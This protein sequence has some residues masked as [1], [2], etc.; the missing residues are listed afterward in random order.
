MQIRCPRCLAI[1]QIS[2]HLVSTVT[3]CRSCGAMLAIPNQVR[4]AISPY[5]RLLG[6]PPAEQ[7]PS[8]RRLIGL[9]EYCNDPRQI[10]AAGQHQE[11]HLQAF[12]GGPHSTEAER[13][14][15]E[16]LH[17]Q[18][19]LLGAASRAMLA[20]Q[21]APTRVELPKTDYVP[22]PF[23]SAAPNFP[24][25]PPAAVPPTFNP[26]PG[27]AEVLDALPPPQPQFG[28][29]TP[30]KPAAE[31]ALPQGR[32]PDFTVW[33]IGGCL[34]GGLLLA[35]I[36]YAVSR[37]APVTAAKPNAPPA[38]Q[39]VNQ[40]AAPVS[41]AT[42]PQS[43]PPKMSQGS[44]SSAPA[45]GS[46]PQPWPAAPPITQ[47]TPPAN[48]D[49]SLDE[50]RAMDRGGSSGAPRPTPRAP[51]NPLPLERQTGRFLAST[52]RVLTFPELIDRSSTRLFAL[53]AE[54]QEP[55]EL[56]LDFS[57]ADLKEGQS[58]ALKPQTNG[59]FPT[60]VLEF[61]SDSQALVLARLTQQ[62]GG[63]FWEWSK[64]VTSAI[65][66]QLW[67]CVVEAKRGGETVRF[68]LRAEKELAPLI[69]DLSAETRS[70]LPVPSALN[71]KRVF[72]ELDPASIPASLKLEGATRYALGKDAVLASVSD[73]CAQIRL[74]LAAIGESLQL[75]VSPVY[76]EAKG[77]TFAFTREQLAK[78]MEGVGETLI[79]SEIRLRSEQSELLALQSSYSSVELRSAS[80][81]QQA[82]ARLAALNLIKG[83]ISSCNNAIARLQRQITEFQARQA[84]GP[85]LASLLDQ[86]DKSGPIRYRVLLC[87]DRHD[88]VLCNAGMAATPRSAALP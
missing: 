44:P 7:P 36:G 25:P 29:P 46:A 33:I 61:V 28:L 48:S 55:L 39:A 18:G 51:V 60:W 11:R 81:I 62:P 67:D 65:A 85:R 13:L 27:E 68:A 70:E 69:I 16:V 63:V 87:S 4:D 6:I 8:P 49:P 23:S 78:T 71:R 40:P 10:L 30:A 1:L 41:P 21:P 82:Q 2:D 86:I 64:F 3:P 52:T 80:T 74:R 19:Q 57:S 79:K 32:K 84:A 24:V 42:P 31:V 9:P 58:F 56:T 34:A 17:A 76:D 54:N 22:K 59:E 43:L 50:M 75:A 88:I 5:E 77:G 20:P 12:L 35:L 37:P 26:R 72:L 47:V 38:A 66:V 14:L 53:P 83:K 15:G 45:S 73:P